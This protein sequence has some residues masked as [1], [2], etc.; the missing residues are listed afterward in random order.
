[1]EKI[2]QKLEENPLLFGLKRN[3][4]SKIESMG[5]AQFQNAI[6]TSLKT[7]NV[8]QWKNIPMPI[9]QATTTLL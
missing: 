5:P 9:C 7:V 6:D 2:E 8:D 4:T 3:L 1:M